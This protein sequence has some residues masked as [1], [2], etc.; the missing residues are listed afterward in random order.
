[1]TWARRSRAGWPQAK[2]WLLILLGLVL[3]G[4]SLPPAQPADT[5]GEPEVV[6]PET[7][8][9]QPVEAEPVEPEPAPVEATPEPAPAPL[10]EPPAPARPVECEPPP[11]AIKQLGKRIIVGS[12]EYVTLSPPDTHQRAR[13]DTGAETS[14]IG[15]AD[16]RHF[17]RDGKR[18]IEVTFP[19]K[20]GEP[21]A[22]IRRPLVRMVR[23][24]RHNAESVRRPVIK[25]TVQLG[26]IKEEIEFTLA[27]RDDFDYPVL[28]GRNLLSGRA[29]V[30]VSRK[31][32]TLDAPAKP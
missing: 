21:E 1:M 26:S 13:I 11:K 28:I 29:V 12:A 6:A 7:P 8:P 27:D 4:C 15:I 25:L 17:E 9:E 18:W 3:A 22:V 16:Y 32:I 19:A 2:C 31:Y 23:I 14:S 5:P 24:K 10:P 20:D 30:D